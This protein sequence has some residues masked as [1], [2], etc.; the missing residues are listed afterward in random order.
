MAAA[1]A[2]KKKIQELMGNRDNSIEKGD[3]LEK[4]L[5]EMKAHLLKVTYQFMP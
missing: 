4:E 2:L 5:N 3:E 1:E